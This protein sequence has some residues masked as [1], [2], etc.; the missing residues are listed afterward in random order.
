MQSKA[1]NGR[2]KCV[3]L[4]VLALAASV[5]PGGAAQLLQKQAQPKAP[6]VE[7]STIHKYA[8]NGQE[9]RKNQVYIYEYTGRSVYRV[10]A[11]PNWSTMIGGREFASMQDA[12]VVLAQA[13]SSFCATINPN[14]G[15]LV[16][17]KNARDAAYIRYQ[18]NSQNVGALND[19]KCADVVF[20]FMERV[21]RGGG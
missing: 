17:A 21:A 15:N 1:G 3:T 9:E 14:V 6:N 13:C 10:V 11:P 7:A 19:Y 8:C 12:Q 4:T 20:R 2:L 5:M 16:A 18:Q